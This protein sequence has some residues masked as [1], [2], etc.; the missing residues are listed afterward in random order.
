MSNLTD[1]VWLSVRQYG[2]ESAQKSF[3]KRLIYTCASFGGSLDDPTLMSQTKKGVTALI[4]LLLP[5]SATAEPRSRAP[6][7][8]LCEA[9]DEPT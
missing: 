3:T 5:L 1:G 7:V 2:W 8:R 6:C 4:V 9:A